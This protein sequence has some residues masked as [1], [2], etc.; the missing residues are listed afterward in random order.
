MHI[1]DRS[2]SL[3]VLPDSDT[4]LAVTIAGV[5]DDRISITLVQI[6]QP[7]NAPYHYRVSTTFYQEGAP[8]SDHDY[9]SDHPALVP[10]MENLTHTC[11]SIHHALYPEGEP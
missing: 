7:D 5:R 1:Q 8:T 4:Q 3:D 6:T 10:A 11:A 2:V 9:S